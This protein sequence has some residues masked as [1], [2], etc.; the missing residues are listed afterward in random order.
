MSDWEMVGMEDMSDDNTKEKIN[1]LTKNMKLD[2][3]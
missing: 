1:I 3:G 2:Q